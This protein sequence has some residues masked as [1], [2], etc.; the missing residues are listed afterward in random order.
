[1]T[2]LSPRDIAA[3]AA[4]A[5]E[6]VAF[7]AGGLEFCINIMSVREIRG[8]TPATAIPRAPGYI[9][10]VI[11]LRGVVLPI[12]DL[13]VRLGLPGTEPTARHVIIV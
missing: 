10:G 5:A 3:E 12:V 13:G 7:R 6:F 1:M 11:N 9:R 4:R 2:D 8:W